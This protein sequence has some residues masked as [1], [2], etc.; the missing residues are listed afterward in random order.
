MPSP[1]DIID[2]VFQPFD[3]TNLIDSFNADCAA[4]DAFREETKIHAIELIFAFHAWASARSEIE[5]QLAS[6]SLEKEMDAIADVEAEQ[7]QMRVRLAQFVDSIR[8]ALILLA[9][10]LR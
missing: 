8:D 9:Q 1:Q 5:T 10:S 6:E 7:D 3:Q 2:A 4:G